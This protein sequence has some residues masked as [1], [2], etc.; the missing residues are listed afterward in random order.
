MRNETTLVERVVVSK[1][2]EGELK[3]FDVDLHKTQDGYAVYV[4]DPEETFEE[5]PF[6]LTSIEKAKQVFDACITLIMQEPVSS[7]ETPFYFAERV[8]V[9]LTEFVHNLEG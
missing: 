3:T 1:A 4:Y 8:Y 6:L 7:T 5:P 2:I 9:K